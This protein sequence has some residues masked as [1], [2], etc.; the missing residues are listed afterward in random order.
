MFKSLTIQCR[1]KGVDMKRG[2]N[3]ILNL[4][5]IAISNRYTRRFLLN[6]I[7][8]QMSK[9]LMENPDGRP[10][11]VQEDKDLMGK[12]LLRSIERAFERNLISKKSAKGILQVFMGNVFHGGFYNRRKFKEKHGSLPPVFITISPTKTCNLTCKGCYA[13]ADTSSKK[14]PYDIFDNIIKDAKRSWGACFF[15]ISGGEPLLYKDAQKGMI[16]IAKT[17]NDCYFLMYTNGSLIDKN[18][19]ELLADCGNITPA[20]SV[21]GLKEETDKRRGEGVY[22]K[23]LTAMENLRGCGVPFGISVTVTKDNPTV[24]VSDEFIDFYFGKEGAIYGWYFHYMPI[25]RGYTMNMLPSPEQR[26]KLLEEE[27]RLV[28]ER[29]IFLVDFWN[30][31]TSSTGCIAGARPGGYFYIDW[32][33]NIC[34]CVFIPYY[35]DNVI[36][37]YKE[38]KTLADAIESK[39]FTRIRDWQA[40]YGYKRQEK[41]VG[42]WLRQ[43]PIRD[44]YGIMHKILLETS[45]KP[46]DPSGEKIINDENHKKDL[47]S[48]GERIGELTEEKWKREYL[49]A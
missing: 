29:E 33:G 13:N 36:E 15:V 22:K 19:A 24:V 12:V 46:S 7:E 2:V 9:E 43:C 40:E 47:V 17:H 10:M 27:W 6:T 48:Y 42:N 41:E 21:E 1:R 32:N 23:I 38:G 35:L 5:E 45:A 14:L 49:M 37:L 16:D 3:S 20:I 44:H 39:L 4:G 31:G 34:P 11:K 8:K 18:I 28:R 26:I 30:S 25:G